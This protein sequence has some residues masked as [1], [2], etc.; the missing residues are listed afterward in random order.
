VSEQGS[1]V[2]G[3]AERVEGMAA[4]SA[5]GVDLRAMLDTWGQI[6]EEVG[7]QPAA[8]LRSTR[9][10]LA[11]LG[12][13]LTGG[14][15]IVV[16]E[17]DPRFADPA[18]REHPLFRRLAQGYLA[19]GRSLDT[20][21][22]SSGLTGIQRERARFV[23]NAAKDVLAPANALPSNPEAMRTLI[24]TRGAS[25]L[26]GIGNFIDDVRHNHGYPAV[27]DRHA[28]RVG[29]DVA[30]STGSV[31][32]RTPLFELIQYHPKT[33]SVAPI[34]LLYVFSQVNRFYLGDLTPDRSLF[35]RLLDAGIPVFA[36]SWKNPTEAERHWNIET[37]AG[38]IIDAIE[39]MRAVTA[40][41]KVH[42]IG[43][44]AGGIVASVAAGVLRARGVD[45]IDALSLFV[46]VLDNRPDDS[47]FGLFV[48]ERSVAA[49]KALVRARGVFTERN[50]F[51]MFA[52]LRVEE[53][54]MS[55]LR[56]NYLLGKAP[57]KHPLLFWSRDYTRVPA[58]FQCDLLDLSQANRLARGE[59]TALGCRVDL[60]AIDYPVYLMAGSTDHITPWKACYRSTQLFGGAVTFVLTNQN[61][62]QTISGRLDNRHL[63]HQVFRASPE[64][65]EAGLAEA[66]THTGPWTFHWIDWLRSRYRD[67]MPAPVTLGSAEYPPLYPAPGRYV[68]DA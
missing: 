58:E 35:Q 41:P 49:Q 62:T 5:F 65:P 40:Q 60:S 25:L 34:P 16:D 68:V 30:A 56:A 43:V 33:P 6:L 21:L 44:C 10:L 7:A 53:N 46:N 48:S 19:W 3:I 66:E 22:D 64:D 57:L 36:I 13:V 1:A 61:H 31:I 12:A 28:F 14:S 54:I 42:L 2:D 27:A 4:A 47:D 38:G 26:R 8:A 11:D 9:S 63:Q 29:R 45:W 18:W 50:V 39:V 24:E 23:L 37:Y 59:L 55:F 15:D 17:R 67:T 32:Y 51:E 20:W 52:L